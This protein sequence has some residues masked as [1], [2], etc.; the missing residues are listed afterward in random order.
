VRR[1]ST[2][3]SSWSQVARI[4][5]ALFDAPEHQEGDLV[6]APPREALHI[7]AALQNRR[8]HEV[9]EAQGVPRR[10]ELAEHPAKRR[11]SHGA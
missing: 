8:K 10:L 6:G 3:A 7:A 5:D 4:G 9:V 1:L 2:A 11:Q